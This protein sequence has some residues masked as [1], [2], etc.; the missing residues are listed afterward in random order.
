LNACL[1]LISTD[2]SNFPLG[3]DRER[4]E[5]EQ[6]VDKIAEEKLS[7]LKDE[8][9]DHSMQELG[10]REV[11]IKGVAVDTTTPVAP[12]K[13]QLVPN[14]I[15]E[16]EQTMADIKISIG[17]TREEISHNTELY[18]TMMKHCIE[19]QEW[20]NIYEAY[21]AM[22]NNHIGRKDSAAARVSVKDG[23]KK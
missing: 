7:K 20:T 14:F 18:F 19:L 12:Y 2:T 22:L 1:N 16:L 3:V 9:S 10:E 4:G 15:R 17:S 23:Q 11:R 21:G 5:D 13:K 6:L 8:F